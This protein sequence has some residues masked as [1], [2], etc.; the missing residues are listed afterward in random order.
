MSIEDGDGDE[1]TTEQTY[2]GYDLTIYADGTVDVSRNG[3]ST[4][5]GASTLR[6]AKMNIDFEIMQEQ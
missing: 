5:L 4:M 1:G 2:R 6:D 3:R